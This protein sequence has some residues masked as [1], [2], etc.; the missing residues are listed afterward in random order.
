MSD[1]NLYDAEEYE[2]EEMEE[3]IFHTDNLEDFKNAILPLMRNE[4]EVWC[5]KIN[6]IITENNYSKERFAELCGVSR[7]SVSKW[8]KGARPSSREDFIRI[9]LAAEYTLDEMNSFLQRYGKHPALYSKSLEDSVYT[10]VLNS[11]DCPHTYDFCQELLAEIKARM[12]NVDDSGKSIYDTWE[13]SRKLSQVSSLS[14]L[15]SFIET[16]AAEYRNAYARLYA[17]INAFIAA[18]SMSEVEEGVSYSVNFLANAQGWT[19][20]LRKCVSAIRQKKWIPLRRKVIALGLNLNM[21]REQINEML[22]LAQM[23]PLYVKNPVEGVI[24]YAL[25]DAELSDIICCNGGTELCE[26]VRKALEELEITDV[27]QLLND[28]GEVEPD[29]KTL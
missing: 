20:S 12:E 13:L 6:D 10:Y 16:N 4:R 27:E 26:Y 1:L 2:T 3:M 28:L 7:Q 19:S 5:A 15:I 22:S 8:C 24:F 21:T 11:S 29:E 14:E 18:N 9:G 25:V 23:E 17:Y